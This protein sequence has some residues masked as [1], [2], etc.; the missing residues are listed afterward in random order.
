MRRSS[1][2]IIPALILGILS[3][4][5]AAQTPNKRQ[6]RPTATAN[7]ASTTEA[8]Q[9]EQEFLKLEQ[10]W[11]TAVQKQDDQ[12]LERIMS[13]EFVMTSSTFPGRKTTKVQF[14]NT[15]VE[16]RTKLGQFRFDQVVVRVIGNVAVVNAMFSQRAKIGDLNLN[17]DYFLTD[18]WLKQET[19]WKVASR[20]LMLAE[21]EDRRAE[22]QQIAASTS[23]ASAQDNDQKRKPPTACQTNCRE[24]FN[25]AAKLCQVKSG[26]GDEASTE[27]DV[28]CMQAAS[29]ALKSC[30]AACR[31]E[32]KA[33]REAKLKT[34]SAPEAARRE[35]RRKERQSRTEAAKPPQK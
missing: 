35:A 17:G 18:V 8:G 33:A 12:T 19:G 32:Q 15:S 26:E 27:L 4:D 30:N 29:A 10:E 14:I 20:N 31:T 3:V 16:P 7:T 9:V 25:A 24:Q 11:M 6:A 21:K 23:N 34:L 13:T 22:R 2:R 5:L 1:L 28:P